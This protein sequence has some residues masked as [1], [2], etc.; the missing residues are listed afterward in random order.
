M[1]VERLMFS[2]IR[3]EICLNDRNG[4]AEEVI[5]SEV[6]PSLFAL[7]DAHDMS[8]IVSN[9]LVKKGL[10]LSDEI[11]AKFRK[12][13]MV[14]V[15][16]YER[17]NYE[18]K[19]ITEALEKAQ[20]DFIPLKGAVIR[21]FYP[22]AWMR[23]C[24]DIDILVKRADLDRATECLVSVGYIFKSRDT[25]DVSLYSPS[26]VHIELH[27]DLVEDGRAN[28][29][30]EILDKVWDHAHVRSGFK[31]WYELEDDM[32]W[33]YH[34][35]HMA[36]HFE[37]GGCG[38]KPFLDMWILEN[39]IKYDRDKRNVLLEKG[40]LLKF[41]EYCERLAKVWF[42]GEAA[43]DTILALEGYV[44]RGG[45]YGSVEN[46]VA[47]KQTKEGGKFKYLISRVFLPYDTLKMIYPIL[48]RHKWLL[49][50]MQVRRWVRI[51]FGGRA[52]VAIRELEANRSMSREKINRTEELF[53]NIGL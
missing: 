12:R 32:F 52:K 42:D 7:S 9:S 46:R 45:V 34:V 37:V 43:D 13:Q 21:E 33:F 40:G 38:I 51:L 50:I 24:C 20:I 25:H 4:M 15:L 6:L 49:P 53:K 26:G 44:L 29:S 47:A 22:E 28:K 3:D 11:S 48:Q 18:Y 2:L 41:S 31:F 1:S 14:A 5:S 10:L 35:A 27:F 16:R 19:V 36:K 30:R 39:R 17:M 8:H 23:T